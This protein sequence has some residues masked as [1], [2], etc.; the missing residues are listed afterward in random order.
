[1]QINWSP[2]IVVL[3]L[4]V[5]CVVSFL[6]ALLV[7]RVIRNG[8]RSRPEDEQLQQR[9]SGVIPRVDRDSEEWEALARQFEQEL[10]EE[11]ERRNRAAGA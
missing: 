4:G 11:H 3:L 5:W 8:Q 6:F 7:G 10:A 9:S 2:E 1:M